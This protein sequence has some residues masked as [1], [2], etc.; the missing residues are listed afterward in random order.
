[1][2]RKCFDYYFQTSKMHDWTPKEDLKEIVTGW[3]GEEETAVT[4]AQGM[5]AALWSVGG[6][7]SG[8]VRIY[9]GDLLVTTV[10]F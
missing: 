5:C 3:W 6:Y 1:M 7:K 10:S 9:E 2:R 8:K 4:T